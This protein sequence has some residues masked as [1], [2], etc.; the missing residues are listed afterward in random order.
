MCLFKLLEMQRELSEM[1]GRQ[2][3]LTTPGSLSKY[4][5]DDV[6]ALAQALYDAA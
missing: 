3:Y 1:I 4:F 6:L 2:V 5:R